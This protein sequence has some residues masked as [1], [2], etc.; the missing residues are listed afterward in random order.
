MREKLEFMG[1]SKPENELMAQR[2]GAVAANAIS[3]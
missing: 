3:L 1:E 2:S